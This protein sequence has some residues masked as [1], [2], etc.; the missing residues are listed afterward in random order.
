MNDGGDPPIDSITIGDNVIMGWG[1]GI[2][3]GAEAHD[4][5]SIHHNVIDK[6][7]KGLESVYGCPGFKDN[8]LA[9]CTTGIDTITGGGVFG[10][11]RFF[12]VTTRFSTDGGECSILGFE[13]IRDRVTFP[14]AGNLDTTIGPGGANDRGYGF[15]T[16]HAYHSDTDEAQEVTEV[17]WDGSSLT[18][19]AKIAREPGAL[20]VSVV[21]SGG[22]ILAR[23]ANSGAQL[24]SGQVS[25]AFNGTW[26]FA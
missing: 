14:S 19:T 7:G 26:V 8:L 1:V 13:I 15:C 25:V 4:L 16:T 21:S 6:C 12:N 10:F 11:T 9:N 22:A 23:V 17:T 20:S 24:T 5:L 18:A 3:S 2:K